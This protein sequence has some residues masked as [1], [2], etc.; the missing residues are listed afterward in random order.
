[1]ASYELVMALTQIQGSGGQNNSVRVGSG[2]RLSPSVTTSSAQTGAY[3]AWCA[4]NTM[5]TRVVRCRGVVIH[6]MVVNIHTHSKATMTHGSRPTPQAQRG[7]RSLSEPMAVAS[8][9]P[10]V[11][12]QRGVVVD[13]RPEVDVHGLQRPPHRPPARHIRVSGLRS[14]VSTRACVQRGA[15]ARD[16]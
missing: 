9:A 5:D 2:T 1:M 3:R 4:S 11:N 7:S 10:L 13:E 6:S 15:G 8:L 14:H 12:M 16:K